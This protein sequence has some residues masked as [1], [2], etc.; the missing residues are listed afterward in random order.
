MNVAEFLPDATVTVGETVAAALLL[1]SVTT[2]PP[3]PALPVKL[4]V[5]VAEFPPVTVEG[6]IPI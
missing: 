5:P 2:N 6:S 4:T 3:A 1:E